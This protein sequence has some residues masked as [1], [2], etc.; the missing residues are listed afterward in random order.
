MKTESPLQTPVAYNNVRRL[1]DYEPW[2]GMTDTERAADS[3]ARLAARDQH[4]AFRGRVAPLVASLVELDTD[5]PMA[6]ILQFPTR[7]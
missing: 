6:V 2:F 5:T 1:E 7:A 3:A 4:P